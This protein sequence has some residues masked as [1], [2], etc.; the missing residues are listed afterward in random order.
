M[1]AALNSAAAFRAGVAPSGAAQKTFCVTVHPDWHP[2]TSDNV[3]AISRH[4][5]RKETK[6]EK[7]ETFA[8]PIEL[9]DEEL[10][11]VAAGALVDVDVNVKTGDIT[12]LNNIAVLSQDFSQ[13]A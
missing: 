13:K 11:R 5:H 6:M 10:D 1:L 4:L 7:M 9:H 2:A 3:A 8:H 12:A